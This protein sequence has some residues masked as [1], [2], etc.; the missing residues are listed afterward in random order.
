MTVEIDKESYIGDGV[1]ASFDGYQIILRTPRYPTGGVTA[2][3]DYWIA[4]E[5]P[6]FAA[7]LVFKQDVDAAIK[8]HVLGKPT[9]AED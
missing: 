9:Q 3:E 8:E 1:Y 4:L 7:L 6:V 5:P 2:A